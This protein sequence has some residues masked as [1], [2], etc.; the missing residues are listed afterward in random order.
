[1]SATARLLQ[2][3]SVGEVKFHVD[4]HGVTQIR[5]SGASKVRLPRG[6]HEAILINTGGGIAGGD[7]FSIDIDVGHD[8]RLT[9][10]SQ[11]A[12]RVYRTL[13]PSASIAAKMKV[14]AGATLHWLPHE[15]IFYDGAALRRD[16]VVDLDAGSKFLAVEPLVFGRDQ[17]G[18]AITNIRLKDTWRIRRGGDLAHADVLTLGPGLPSSKATLAGAAALATIVYVYEDAELLLPAVRDQ[19]YPGSGAS[20]WNGKLIARLL[21]Q[22]GF[23]LLKQIIS[24]L[25]ALS[26]PEALPKLWTF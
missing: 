26:G 21:A 15:T 23:L 2:Q 3:R 24:V 16:Y 19:L 11:A 5:E 4:R 10:T 17:M 25:H 6:S 20:A 14:G 1:M 7:S 13:G 8:T 18:E 12:E 9:I 22:D